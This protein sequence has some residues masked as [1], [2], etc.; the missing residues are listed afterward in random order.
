MVVSRL[1]SRDVHVEGYSYISH[2]ALKRVVAFA[3]DQVTL[4][5]ELLLLLRVPQQV[6]SCHSGHYQQVSDPIAFLA[7]QVRR[8]AVGR[9]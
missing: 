2:K 3:A 7:D 1:K 5:V 6:H 9:C 4:G 8:L